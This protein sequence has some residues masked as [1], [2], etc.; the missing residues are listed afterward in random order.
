MVVAASRRYKSAFMRGTELLRAVAELAAEIQAA[1]TVGALLST[2][3][4]SLER[5]GFDVAVLSLTQE[6]RWF[7]YLTD[8]PPLY[9]VAKALGLVGTPSGADTPN[10]MLLPTPLQKGRAFIEDL[11]RAVAGWVGAEGNV[12]HGLKRRGLVVPLSL[13]PRAWGGIVFMHDELDPAA[14]DVLSLFA[15]QLGST[16]ELLDHDERLSQR[17]AELALVRELA[18]AGAQANPAALC[19]RALTFTCRATG[20]DAG[21]LFRFEASSGEYELIGDVYGYEGPLTAKYGRFKA[22][23]QT[24]TQLTCVATDVSEGWAR[25]LAG[26]GFSWLAVVPLASEGAPAGQ[27]ILVRRS[28]LRYAE[29][30]LHT[31][32]VLGAQMLGLIERA[33]LYEETRRLLRVSVEAYDELAR[34]Q[35]ELVRHERLAALGELAAVMAHEVRNPL[36]VIFNSL[37]TL[38]RLLHPTGDAEMLLDMVEEEA[39]R[40]NRIVSDLLDFVRPYELAKRPLA[41]GPLVETAVAEALQVQPAGNATVVTECEEELPLFPAD[42]HLLKQA[43]VNLVVNAVQAMPKGGKVTVRSSLVPRAGGAWAQ[44]EVCDEGQGLSPRAAERMF[45]PFFTTKATGTGLGLAV[46]KRIVESHQGEVLVSPNADRGTTFVVRL[47][48]ASERER[49]A[50]AMVAPRASA[51]P[52]S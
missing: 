28:P 41:I 7:Q 36:G 1:K 33:R 11:P 47:P 37:T 29:V 14:S 30:E 34:A 25:D 5:L 4:A 38:K 46:V 39:E 2:T 18:V 44:I 42:A 17:N 21:S 26:S 16:I 48:P 20:S 3:G 32:E 49:D 12:V 23:S 19:Q 13:G 45:Q 24:P 43:I 31:A 6:Q 27:L 10:P 22:T 40:L 15:L 52:P 50:P 9:Q 35:A 51:G 8:R